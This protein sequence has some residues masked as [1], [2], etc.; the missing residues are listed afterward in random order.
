MKNNFSTRH[1]RGFSLIELLVSMAI[2]LF[3]M[4]GAMSIFVSSKHSYAQQD[5]SSQMQEN[6]R[7]AL[8]MLARDTRIAGMS[9][10]SDGISIANTLQD[11][12]AYE[13]EAMSFSNGLTGYVGDATNSTFPASFK[14]ISSPNTDAIV[15]HSMNTDSELIV[16][17]H[18]PNSATIS[19]TTSDSTLQQGDIVMM[20]DSNCTNMAVFANTGPANVAN[21]ASTSIHN[22]GNIAG[23]DYQNCSKSVKGSFSCGDT[24]GALSLAY[25]SGSSVFKIE[26]FAYYIAP[27]SLDAAILSLYRKN[28]SDTSIAVEEMVEGVTDLD[29]YYG[30]KLG[31]NTQYLQADGITNANWVNVQSVRY[32]VT[33]RSLSLVSGA[34]VSKTFTTTIK[35]RNRG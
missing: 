23:E 27:S 26:S 31:S 22:T 24:T 8:E 25:T 19:F 29:I 12:G 30:L 15:I 16:S 21:N 33:V 32:K 28:V 11:T 4:L 9:G 3:I 5:A 1:L 10:C 6:A 20:I 18:N 35:L 14:D 7:F 13:G 17:S 34:P 2:G